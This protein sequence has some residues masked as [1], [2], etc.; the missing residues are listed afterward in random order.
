[1]QRKVKVTC[2]RH[3]FIN[4][5]NNFIADISS[6]G[7]ASFINMISDNSTNFLSFRMKDGKDV[8]VNKYVIKSMELM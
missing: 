5:S 6:S 2:I 8:F 4:G 1:M 7:Y 3:E